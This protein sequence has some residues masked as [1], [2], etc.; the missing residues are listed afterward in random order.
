MILE[1]A[2]PETAPPM[3]KG[4]ELSSPPTRDPPSGA[5]FTASAASEVTV[6]AGISLA[7]IFFT[8]LLLV[9]T[10]SCATL[11]LAHPKKIN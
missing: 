7:A 2:P 5:D 11:L 9:E 10:Y 1:A 8:A 6:L 4:F 3:N